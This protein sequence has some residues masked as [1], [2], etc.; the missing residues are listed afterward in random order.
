MFRLDTTPSVAHSLTPC[1]MQH[2]PGLNQHIHSHALVESRLL[3]HDSC[4]CVRCEGQ[5][6]YITH[7]LPST[8]LT[9]SKQR[10]SAWPQIT[11]KNDR[12]NKIYICMR[13][14]EL[15]GVSRLP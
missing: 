8:S 10:N 6:T 9:G 4:I 13:P 11:S 5:C 3:V 7:G 1:D 2:P 14:R 12:A 15:D